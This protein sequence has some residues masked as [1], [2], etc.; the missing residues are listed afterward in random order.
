ML[1]VKE[2]VSRLKEKKHHNIGV[3]TLKWQ[4]HTNTIL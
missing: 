2:S 3:P 4:A 1:L